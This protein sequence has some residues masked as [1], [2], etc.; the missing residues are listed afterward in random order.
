MVKRLGG[1][2]GVEDPFPPRPKGMHWKTY[3]RLQAI[4]EHAQ[5][6]WGVMVMQFM[7]RL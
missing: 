3:D 5:D 4:D 2:E 7:E 6:L 1:M